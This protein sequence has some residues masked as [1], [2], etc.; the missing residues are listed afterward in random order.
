MESVPTPR[1]ELEASRAVAQALLERLGV[2]SAKTAFSARRIRSF[3]RPNRGE[4][5]SAPLKAVGVSRRYKQRMRLYMASDDG[6]YPT[7][8]E[9]SLSRAA[10]YQRRST[11]RAIFA[12]TFPWELGSKRS[13]AD[14]PWH[15]GR[16][17]ARI[18]RRSLTGAARP[19]VGDALFPEYEEVLTRKRLLSATPINFTSGW[20][21]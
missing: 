3:P 15:C 21:C 18:R 7:L 8:S 20:R 17:A 6:P 5:N 4:G 11:T 14:Q 12:E 2:E 1:G 9:V 19:L 10:D 13:R 16:M